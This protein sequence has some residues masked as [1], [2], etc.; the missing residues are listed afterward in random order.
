MACKEGRQVDWDRLQAKIDCGADFVVTQLFFKNEF[1]LEM[2]DYLD[3]KGVKVPLLPGIIPI[4]SATQIKRFTTMCGAHLPPTLVA[5]LEKLGDNEAAAAEYGIEYATRQ[6]AEL[7]REGVS[8]LHFYT[9]NKAPTV[10]R[11]VKNLHLA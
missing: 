1:Y 8:G 2:R 9:L 6:C 3:R 11:I 7:L 4:Q 10:T 5:D